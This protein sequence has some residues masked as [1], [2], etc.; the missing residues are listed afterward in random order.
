MFS[1]AKKLS[2]VCRKNQRGFALIITIVLVAF[3][4]LIVVGLGIFSRVETTVASNAQDVAAARQNALMGLNIA[5]GD[6]Q[7]YAGKDRAVTATAEHFAPTAPHNQK[8]FYTGVWNTVAGFERWLVSDQAPDPTTAPAPGW[9]DGDDV[10]LVGTNTLGSTTP[11]DFHVYA[12]RRDVTST[13]IP[14]FPAAAS[15][16]I[17][18]YAYWVS[19]EGAKLNLSLAS[20]VSD[21]GYTGAALPTPVN[22]FFATVED[23][24]RVSQR[25]AHRVGLETFAEFTLL[26]EADP[27]SLLRWNTLDKVVSLPQAQ[28]ATA[29]GVDATARDYLKARFHDFTVSSYGVLSDSNN[30]DLR[31]NWSDIAGASLPQAWRDYL[32]FRPTAAGAGV[33][34]QIRLGDVETLSGYYSIR[35][36]FTELAIDVVPY[37]RVADGVLVI[38]MRIRVELANPY[39]LPIYQNA[40]P[41][42]DGYIVD[43]SDLP[44]I[45]VTPQGASAIPVN[46]QNLFN[47]SE[48][49]TGR[50]RLPITTILNPGEVRVI[51]LERTLVTSDTVADVTPSD[52]TDD[53]LRYDS[54]GTGPY[55]LDVTIEWPGDAVSALSVY[56]N[57]PFGVFARDYQAWAG[58]DFTSDGFSFHAA[59]NQLLENWVELTKDNSEPTIAD[60]VDLR[61]QT[62]DFSTAEIRNYFDNSS[63]DFTTPPSPRV[64]AQNTQFRAA[65]FF[66]AA[67]TL[68][69]IFD[70]PTGPATPVGLFSVGELAHMPMPQDVSSF[71]DARVPAFALGR[72]EAG[73]TNEFFDRAIFIPVNAEWNYGELLP[74][75]RYLPVVHGKFGEPTLAELQGQEA[76][77]FLL[78][79]GSFNVNSTSIPAWR[80]I[81]ARSLVDWV[82][83]Q[84]V[85]LNGS[86]APFPPV[87]NPIISRPHTSHYSNNASANDRFAMRLLTNPEVTALATQIVVQIRARANPFESVEE[88]FTSPVLETAITAAGLN[89]GATPIRQRGG[90]KWVTPDRLAMALAPFLSARSDTF[91]VRAYGASKNPVTQAVEGQA[92]LEAVV[93]RTPEWVAPGAA[94]ANELPEGPAAGFGRRFK[95]VSLRWLTP[96]DI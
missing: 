33:L 82:D 91:V 36:L 18:Q 67:A 28:F 94:P 90:E 76:A 87:L 85:G 19:D 66:V 77:L 75:T 61:W 26:S 38:R 65:D 53:Q 59:V 20:E 84:G 93:Q 49:A 56:Q 21:L 11:T 44:D 96:S 52:S 79:K 35:P 27:A 8:R 14:G 63:G 24:D 6:L 10:L 43:L 80:G 9:N 37:R 81:L 29:L 12:E 15:R 3:L 71:V 34:P 5:L 23:R 74:N 51:E 2:P 17:G 30:G 78:A 40:A 62:L 32:N 55:A 83:W 13:G 25:F 54:V 58:D 86:A 88:F 95:I 41:P 70:L 47:A 31:D 68:P 89:P 69:Q 73:G 72:P 60:A 42:D 64:L 46:L 16:Q 39:A 1:S 22:T 92:W 48:T 57:I 4:V 7:R 45:T 50:W